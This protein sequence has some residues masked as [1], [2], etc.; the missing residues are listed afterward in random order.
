MS[1]GTVDARLSEM[2]RGGECGESAIPNSLA[3][4]LT[5]SLLPS[6][7]EGRSYFSLSRTPE[8]VP[9]SHKRGELRYTII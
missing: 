8:L 6:P 9:S 5:L 3:V 7:S 1:V 4:G 2:K